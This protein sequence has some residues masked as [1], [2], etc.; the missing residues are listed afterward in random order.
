MN[1]L[2]LYSDLDEK[3]ATRLV[4]EAYERKPFYKWFYRSYGVQPD[5]CP[6]EDL[7]ILRKQDFFEYEEETGTPY[8]DPLP[9]EDFEEIFT[10][11]TTAK[12]LK[13]LR[14]ARWGPKRLERRS[15]LCFMQYIQ[16]WFSDVKRIIL[17]DHKHPLTELH[18]K[19]FK[20]LGYTIVRV[21]SEKWNDIK[22]LSKVIPS[23]R[24]T[25]L[26]DLSGS[27]LEFLAK[28]DLPLHKMGVRLGITMTIDTKT[29]E[30]LGDEVKVICYFAGREIG[31]MVGANCP[32][33]N[34]YYHRIRNDVLLGVDVR[35]N[36]RQK[37][38][39]DLICT[40]DQFYFPFIKYA[41]GDI[42]RLDKFNCKCGFSGISLQ[43]IRRKMSV[44]VPD[45]SG[46]IVDLKNLYNAFSEQFE[47]RILMVYLRARRDEE[48]IRILAVLIEDSEV[49]M[50]RLDPKLSEDALWTSAGGYTYWSHALPVILVPE[51]SIPRFDSQSVK[52]RTFIN[53]VDSILPTEYK[54]LIKCVEET[55]GY[56][57]IEDD[58]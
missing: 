36:Y 49:N 19:G 40:V 52:K 16:K 55:T 37:G 9:A 11:G 47:G 34:T 46:A 12:P 27:W 57:I 24:P 30:M 48:L 44:K 51:F 18:C 45:N 39:G 22:Y 14:S 29:E 25:C 26:F 58:L 2:S 7:P 1:V 8:Y 17:L 33:Q 38:E 23:S 5:S 21:P 43:F 28:K 35:G 3:A 6:F 13:L 42:V 41:N 50:P 4:I 53:A 32:Y 56:K 20:E 54:H 10:S 31:E 15:I